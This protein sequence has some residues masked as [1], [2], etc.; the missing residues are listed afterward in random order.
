MSLISIKNLSFAYGFNDIFENVNLQIDSN[1]KLGLVGRNG[2][3]K[4]TLLKILNSE[5]E[6][7]GKI[8]CSINFDYFPFEIR[9]ISKN[10]IDAL[11]EL[12]P[13]LQEW[14]IIKELSLLSVDEEILYRPFETLSLGERTKT[15]LA[16]MFIKQNNFLLIDEPT[17][18]LDILGRKTVC[19][20]LKSKQGFIVV[21]HDRDFLDNCVDYILSINRANIEL[22]KG[23][24]STYYQNKQQQDEYEIEKNKKLKKEVRKLEQSARR[25]AQWSDKIESSKIGQ[26]VYDRG[27]VGHQAA[28]MMKRSKNIEK[29]KN[30]AIEEKSSLMKNIDSYEDLTLKYIEYHKTNL[31]SAKNIS[32]FYG[33]NKVFDNLSFDLFKGD[34]IAVRGKNGSGKSSLIKLIAGDEMDFSGELKIPPSIKISYITQITSN[35][36]SDLKNFAQVNNLDETYFKTILRKLDFERKL[37]DMNIEDYSE[38]QRKKV[39]V[40]KSIC[41]EANLYI[42]DE[43]LNYVDVFSK[44]QIEEMILFSEPT[45]IFVEHDE[46]FVNKIAN[47]FIDL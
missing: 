40:A 46:V 25:T 27:F 36:S 16:A 21:S 7:K 38:G 15:M 14:E 31:I 4:T 28:K 13:N 12:N 3:G 43:P 39:L 42:W 41:E 9:N 19:D 18:H 10:T 37:F 24:F 20:Y 2:R 44:I 23:N 1:W 29:R 32:I 17:N 35:L 22:Q 8:D 26:G 11:F 34:R 33:E 6:Y 5:L 45:M 30:K 47:K